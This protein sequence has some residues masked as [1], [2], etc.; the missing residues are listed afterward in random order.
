MFKP[1]VAAGSVRG[2]LKETS[3]LVCIFAFLCAVLICVPSL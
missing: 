1:A 3:S 2:K